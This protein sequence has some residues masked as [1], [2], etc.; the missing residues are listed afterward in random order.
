VKIG[1][2]NAREIDQ[3][4]CCCSCHL[5]PNIKLLKILFSLI[6]YYHLPSLEIRTKTK[7]IISFGREKNGI[8]IL[9]FI[10]LISQF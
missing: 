1:A 3:L 9:I 2:W 6:Y 10:F 4:C 7:T 5:R 8:V